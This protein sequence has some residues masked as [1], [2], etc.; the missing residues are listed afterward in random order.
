MLLAALGG[1]N[2]RTNTVIKDA[3]DHFGI[4]TLV[5]L[6]LMF[7]CAVTRSTLDSSSLKCLLSSFSRPF[8]TLKQRAWSRRGLFIILLRSILTLDK[9]V[10]GVD[11]I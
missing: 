10:G 4:T 9:N 7:A 5:L 2:T 11:F 8:K 3:F 1:L 6:L